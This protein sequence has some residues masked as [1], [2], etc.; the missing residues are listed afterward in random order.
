M[1]HFA[2]G[3]NDERKLHAKRPFGQNHVAAVQMR[4]GAGRS[5]GR[6]LEPL[7]A[8]GFRL[9]LIQRVHKRANTMDDIQPVHCLQIRKTCMQITF[10]RAQ[11]LH[12]A[13]VGDPTS[14]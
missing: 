13:K 10:L 2:N 6:S 5:L 14:F 12:V 8:F 3:V 11:F 4:F 1:S 7:A 9:R